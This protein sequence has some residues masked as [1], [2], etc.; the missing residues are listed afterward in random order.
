[1]DIRP[2]GADSTNAVLHL[3]NTVIRDMKQKGIDQW[4]DIYPSK[5]LLKNDILAGSAWGCFEGETLAGYLAIDAD[6]PKEYAALSWEWG[7]DN[8]L[9]IHRLCIHPLKRQNGYS[10]ALLAAVEK[11]AAETGCKAIRLDTHM[12]NKVAQYTF[13]KNGYAFRGTVEFR[14]GTFFCYEKEL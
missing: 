13:E 6:E 10:Q 3:F 1:M 8:H 14:K 7:I 4:D 12:T 9:M 2:L 5:E 11:W